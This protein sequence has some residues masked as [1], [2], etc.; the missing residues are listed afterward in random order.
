[1]HS[2]LQPSRCCLDL[3]SSAAQ[4]CRRESYPQYL[5]VEQKRVIPNVVKVVIPVEIHGL[6]FAALYLPPTRDAWWHPQSKMLPGVIVANICGQFW[7]G[8]DQAHLTAQDV[9]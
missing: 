6:L 3:S 5:Q 8:P 9:E 4:H 7:P 2:S 1:M